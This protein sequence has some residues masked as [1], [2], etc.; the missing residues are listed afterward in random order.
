M[1]IEFDH[2]YEWLGGHS[3]GASK[4]EG[5]GGGGGGGQSSSQLRS[6]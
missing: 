2:Y 1:F 3:H 4:G 6:A 5:G